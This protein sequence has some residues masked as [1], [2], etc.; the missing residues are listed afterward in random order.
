[1]LNIKIFYL[2]L[3]VLLIYSFFIVFLPYFEFYFFCRGIIFPSLLTII[4]TL[5]NFRYIKNI[6]VCF[7]K[8]ILFFLLAHIFRLIIF[9]VFNGFL[10]INFSNF[11]NDWH[12]LYILMQ[13]PSVLI[14]SFLTFFIKKKLSK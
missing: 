6:F 13:I 1:M 5:I 7:L 10:D 2:S 8:V 11:K 4:L 12:F 9:F 3:L 14:S